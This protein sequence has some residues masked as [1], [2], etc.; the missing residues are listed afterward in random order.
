MTQDD[1]PRKRRRPSGDEG[2][3]CT[4]WI[5]DEVKRRRAG[6]DWSAERLAEEM[7]SAGV[8]WTR[9]VVVNLE[10]GRRNTLA[11]HELLALAWV[12]D[13]SSPADLIVPPGYAGDELFPVTPGTTATPEQLRE[14]FTGKPLRAWI[15][16]MTDQAEKIRAAYDDLR[17]KLQEGDHS[18]TELEAGLAA[19]IDAADTAIA[20]VPRTPMP[21]TWVRPPEGARDGG[22]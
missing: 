17:R 13:V 6:L 16:N 14:W 12:F 4:K 1:S 7:S 9:D 10:N 22:L 2:A 21:D 20:M 3:A 15:R 5:V 8:P 18:G 11:V 19:I